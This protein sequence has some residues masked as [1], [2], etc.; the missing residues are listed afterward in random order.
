MSKPS[1]AEINR[2]IRENK[3]SFRMAGVDINKDGPLTRKE[4]AR[5]NAAL[6][7]IRK[8]GGRK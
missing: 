2:V 1:Q 6:K 3:K 5:V 8:K 7:M 4:A